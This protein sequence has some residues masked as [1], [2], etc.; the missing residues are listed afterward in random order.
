[1]AKNKSQVIEQPKKKKRNTPSNIAHPKKQKEW[2]SPNV[3]VKKTERQLFQDK[4]K[5]FRADKPWKSLRKELKEE[6]KLDELT[7]MKLT[8]RFNLHHICMKDETYFDI[9]NK[10][11][12]STLNSMSHDNTH[13]FFNQLKKKN[14]GGIAFIHRFLLLQL[15]M[16]KLNLEQEDYERIKEE[17]APHFPE[18]IELIDSFN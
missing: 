8:P 13:W 15:K 6:R 9:S 11:H 7:L 1:M 4:K 16:A 10:E 2:A 17:L 5:K 12:F 14:T 3:S 18:L